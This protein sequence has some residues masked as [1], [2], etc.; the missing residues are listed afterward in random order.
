MN[1]LQTFVLGLRDIRGMPWA[2]KSGFIR[3]NGICP[4]VAV[5]GFPG[6][7]GGSYPLGELKGLPHATIHHIMS[8]A[9][10][11]DSAIPS[12]RAWR[13]ILLKLLDLHE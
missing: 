8:A 4:I 5:W 12:H 7:E 1:P 2:P 11:S 9:D 13:G 6:Y 10:T 3:A